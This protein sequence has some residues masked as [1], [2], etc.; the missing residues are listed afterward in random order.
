MPKLLADENFDN[1]IV[2]G[3]LRRKSDVDI[4]RVQDVGLSGIFLFKKSDRNFRELQN[5]YTLYN[6]KLFRNFRE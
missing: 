6:L 5:S 1:T 2:R 4:L 3:L